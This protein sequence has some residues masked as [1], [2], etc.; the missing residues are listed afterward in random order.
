[1]VGE[2][3]SS[4]TCRNEPWDRMLQLTGLHLHED[5][6]P[7][8]FNNVKVMVKGSTILQHKVFTGRPE[9]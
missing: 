3:V 7:P 9:T 1:M 8:T 4:G 6:L 2:I 5:N